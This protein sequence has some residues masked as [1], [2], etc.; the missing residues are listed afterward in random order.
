VFSLSLSL[1]AQELQPGPWFAASGTP[2]LRVSAKGPGRKELVRLELRRSGMA[3]ITQ[4]GPPR[5]VQ[6]IFSVYGTHGEVINAYMLTAGCGSL[7]GVVLLV[8]VFV[9]DLRVYY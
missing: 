4:T 9:V 3:H 1:S 7:E 6:L 8:N 5:H 2:Q